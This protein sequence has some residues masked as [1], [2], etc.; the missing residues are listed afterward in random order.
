[1]APVM[2]YL[3]T[4]G[5]KVIVECK[6]HVYLVPR[7]DYQNG[8]QS[9]IRL[10]TLYNNGQEGGNCHAVPSPNR[11]DDSETR[12]KRSVSSS[13][14]S[15]SVSDGS[16]SNGTPEPIVPAISNS[17]TAA[18]VL[19]EL[20]EEVTRLIDQSI[21]KIELDWAQNL[22]QMRDDANKINTPEPVQEIMACLENTPKSLHPDG[23]RGQVGY[24]E[25]N[26]QV[27]QTDMFVASKRQTRVKLLNEIRD[28]VDRLKDM[29][30][31]EE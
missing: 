11:C 23:D 7:S 26:L 25:Q 28:L 12:A 2:N 4:N 13:Y 21:Q 16:E 9:E 5:K 1:M 20:K 8:I 3:G 17:T 14:S 22:E 30:M 15:A 19:S 31:L 27:L 18:K 10:Q 24:R 29:E 6:G